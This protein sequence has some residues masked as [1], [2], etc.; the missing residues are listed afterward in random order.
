MTASEL[1]SELASTKASEGP[2]RGVHRRVAGPRRAGV[3]IGAGIGDV[4]L[5]R[6]GIGAGIGVPASSWDLA[7][8][9]ELEQASELEEPESETELET[10]VAT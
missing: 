5:V 2:R 6:S 7:P 4:R 9:L 3:R 8:E 1:V 10:E